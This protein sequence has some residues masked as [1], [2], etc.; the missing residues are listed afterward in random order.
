[1]KIVIIGGTSSLG[2]ALLKHLSVEHVVLTAGRTNC[3]IFIDLRQNIEKFDLPKDIDVLVHTAASFGGN[4]GLEIEDM[5][6]IN[7]LGTLKILKSASNSNVKHFI[8]ISSIFALLKPYSPFYNAYSISKRYAE[9]IS[10]YY[11]STNSTGMTLTTLRPSQIYGFTDV[12]RKHQPFFYSIIDNVEKSKDIVIYGSNDP[13]RN[14]IHINDLVCVI[15]R[16]IQF[17]PTGTFNC[18]YPE[19]ISYSQVVAAAKKAF[20][21]NSEIKFILDREDIKDNIFEKDITLYELINYYPRIS[22]LE[23]INLLV[24]HKNKTK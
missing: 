13:K 21:S 4:P 2:L 16:V 23:G 9:E 8:L 11:I 22:I 10:N 5:L 14:Y 15:E 24:K 6:Q 3:D 18:A 17:M 12:F 7:T 20:K 1:M 19:D